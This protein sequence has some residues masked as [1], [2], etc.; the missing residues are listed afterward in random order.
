VLFDGWRVKTFDP[1]YSSWSITDTG[2]IT[3][4]ASLNA[5]YLYPVDANRAHVLIYNAVAL[6]SI[7]VDVTVLGWQNGTAVKVRNVQ[8]YLVDVQELTVENQCIMIGMENRT[9]HQPI[10]HTGSLHYPNLTLHES[11]FPEFGCF[12]LERTS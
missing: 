3:D 8:D 12:V 9:Q 6:S 7:L 5:V 10:A 4:I 11:T 2:T 1:F